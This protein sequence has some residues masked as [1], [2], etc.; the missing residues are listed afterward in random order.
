MNTDLEKVVIPTGR[1]VTKHT[2][3]WWANSRPALR[4][5]LFCIHGKSLLEG[6]NECRDEIDKED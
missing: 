1:I 2:A 3:W 5:E 4:Q 6:C